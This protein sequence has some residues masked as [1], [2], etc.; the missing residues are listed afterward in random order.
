MAI[1]HLHCDIIGRSSGRSAT[2]A[3]A[4]RATCKIEDR[5][6]GDVFDYRRKSKALYTEILTGAN[7]PKW[8][9]NRAELWNSLE[10]KEKRKDAQFCRSFDGALPREF[11]LE[12]NKKLAKEFAQIF[13]DRG[14][15]A[16]L[17]IHGPHED[18]DGRSNEN[19]HFHLLVATR[20]MNKDGWA[21][22]DREAN[23]KAFLK[24]VRKAWA[25]I[26]NAEFERRGMPDRIDERTL[27][28]QGIEREAQ[29]HLGPTATAMQR[30][31]KQTARRRLKSQE[32]EDVLEDVLVTDEELQNALQNDPE[33]LELLDEKDKLLNS[34]E[35]KA[36]RS[37]KKWSEKILAEHT[38]PQDARER[39]R[40]QVASIE[41]HNF[42]WYVHYNKDA[43][44]EFWQK[45]KSPADKVWNERINK[46]IQEVKEVARAPKY[47]DEFMTKSDRLYAESFN[48]ANDSNGEH[49]SAFRKWVSTT[50]FTPVKVARMVIQKLRE[51]RDALFPH[52]EQSQDYHHGRG[53]K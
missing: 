25:D 21:E 3:A 36:E 41:K 48:S 44:V 2:A 24:E 6:T 46:R 35:A 45:K 50:E 53:R 43:E 34:P 4:Y 14:T 31:G 47:R 19:I 33:V 7:A 13:T 1:Y 18:E 32:V 38:S 8:A 20:K 49:K 51:W 40:V 17:A 9:K 22:K 15:P 12:T 5:T 10:E 16:D 37:F 52:L 26:V 23:T 30:K 29:Q 42:F 27:K 39:V 11:D 28:A